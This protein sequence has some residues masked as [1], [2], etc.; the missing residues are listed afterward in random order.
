MDYEDIIFEKKDRIARI[1]INRPQR[2][3][4]CTLQTVHE[5][6]DAFNQCMDNEIGVVVFTGAGDK[7]FCTG[8]D[9]MTREKGGYTGE[10]MLPLEVGWQRVTF[11]I[12]TLPKPVI[13]RVN[14]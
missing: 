9:Q 3:N 2:Y 1:T 7:A 14:G 4:A 13:A 6:I 11:L 12:R 10:Y 5:L 8:G